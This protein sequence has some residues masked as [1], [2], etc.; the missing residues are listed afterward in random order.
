MYR[1]SCAIPEP[2]QRALTQPKVP[3][4]ARPPIFMA[5]MAGGFAAGSFNF[6]NGILKVHDGN[7][8]TEHDRLDT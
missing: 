7:I 6:D 1:S 2:K 3:P 4:A 8:V 5:D